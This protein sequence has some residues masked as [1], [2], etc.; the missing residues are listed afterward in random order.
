MARKQL[1]FLPTPML[2]KKR[3]YKPAKSGYFEINVFDNL[4]INP[5]I[6]PIPLVIVEKEFTNE[7]VD[8]ELPDYLGYEITNFPMFY[9]YELFNR[10]KQ[11]NI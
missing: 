4:F 2:V 5:E 9:G 8:L 1:D 10:V 3:Y 11:S 6:N 7:N